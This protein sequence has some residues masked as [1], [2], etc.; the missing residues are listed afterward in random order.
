MTSEEDFIKHIYGM[1]HDKRNL[2]S[3]QIWKSIKLIAAILGPEESIQ[4]SQNSV[5]I[6]FFI[7]FNIINQTIYEPKKQTSFDSSNELVKGV[8]S[9]IGIMMKRER[10]DSF[11]NIKKEDNEYF[12]KQPGSRRDVKPFDQIKR[13]DFLGDKT[14]LGQFRISRQNKNSHF[15]L[16][17]N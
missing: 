5:A 11:E 15:S 12:V 8:H 3:S 4:C 7:N 9:E 17:Y 13:E 16:H 1:K 10:R 6:E 2:L 14:N